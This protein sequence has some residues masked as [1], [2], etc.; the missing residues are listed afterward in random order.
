LSRWSKPRHRHHSPSPRPSDT[1]TIDE[2]LPRDDF[3]LD[4]IADIVEIDLDFRHHDRLGTP[5][6]GHFERDKSRN[7]GP[8]LDAK[9]PFIAKAVS[10]IRSIASSAVFT[11]VSKPS[12]IGGRDVVVDRRRHCKHA[13]AGLIEKP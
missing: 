1:T 8:S 5:P 2:R 13:T 9:H 4:A 12:Q 3:S 6:I 11:A 7:R 10:R